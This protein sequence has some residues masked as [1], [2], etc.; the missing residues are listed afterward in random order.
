MLIHNGNME[1]E[2][3]KWK[4]DR[5]RQKEDRLEETPCTPPP[6]QETQVA[7]LSRVFLQGVRSLREMEIA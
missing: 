7:V 3:G 1:M 4:E 2:N 6:P 5:A